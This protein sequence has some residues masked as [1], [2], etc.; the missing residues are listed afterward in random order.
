MHEWINIIIIIIIGR[1]TAQ[2]NVIL[3]A[4]ER[5]ISGLRNCFAKVDARQVTDAVGINMLS[6][7]IMSSVYLQISQAGLPFQAKYGLIFRYFVR[8]GDRT[9]RC[10]RLPPTLMHSR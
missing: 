8:D 3:C 4:S 5:T 7:I 2:T 10:C 6:K 9:Q 1:S